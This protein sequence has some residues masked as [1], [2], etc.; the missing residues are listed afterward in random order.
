MDLDTNKVIEDRDAR[1]ITGRER[2]REFKGKPRNI[3]T[4]FTYEAVGEVAPH[5]WECGDCGHKGWMKMTGMC[6]VCKS[7]EKHKPCP[8]PDISVIHSETDG[9]AY[10]WDDVTGNELDAPFVKKD[11]KYVRIFNSRLC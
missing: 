7:Y 9:K 2:R 4:T 5:M 11:G 10:A 8:M 1:E 6:S 3:K